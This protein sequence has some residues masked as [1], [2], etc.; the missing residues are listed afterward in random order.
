VAHRP[1]LPRGPCGP[2]GFGPPIAALTRMPRAGAG[3]AALRAGLFR[4]APASDASWRAATWCV[5]QLEGEPVAPVIVVRVD[6][7]R[8]VVEQVELNHQQP[9]QRWVAP[10]RGRCLDSIGGRSSAR[11]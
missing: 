10:A 11:A 8:A 7:R 9:Q 1:D 2:P 6:D 3:E 4:G 5:Q